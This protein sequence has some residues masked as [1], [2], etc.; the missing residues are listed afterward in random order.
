MFNTIVTNCFAEA[1]AS[2]YTTGKNLYD[3]GNYVQALD[4]FEKSVALDE[5][6]EDGLYYLAMTYKLN[7][8]HDEASAYFTK[9]NEKY[10]ESDYHNS[11][12]QYLQ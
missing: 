4:A 2:L 8:M 12:T 6:S 9:L 3:A 5:N 11:I 7:D 1:A 10:P